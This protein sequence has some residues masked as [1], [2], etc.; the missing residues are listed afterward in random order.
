MVNK[1][2]KHINTFYYCQCND[3]AYCDFN[4]TRRN[5]FSLLSAIISFYII[6][7]FVPVSLAPQN[8]ACNKPEQ[9]RQ[10]HQAKQA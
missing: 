10:K 7:V 6:P 5:L 8:K 3:Q 1:R 4:D 2:R 9:H